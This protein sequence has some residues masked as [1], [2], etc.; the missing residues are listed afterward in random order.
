MEERKNRRGKRITKKERNAQIQGMEG[1]KKKRAM[2]RSKRERQRQ[3]QN[4]GEKKKKDSI[5]TP[6]YDK[7]FFP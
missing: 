5:F 3:L 1:E 4:G 2:C 7:V 6:Q